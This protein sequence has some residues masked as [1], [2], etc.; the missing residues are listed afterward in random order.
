M[1]SCKLSLKNMIFYGH[2]GVYSFE[3]E[4]GQRIEVD[5]ELWADFSVAVK[6]DNL[7]AAIS[8]VDVYKTVKNIVEDESYN[9]IEGMAV[10]IS[11]RIRADYDVSKVT[12]RVRKPQPP[13]GGLMDSA[14]FEICLKKE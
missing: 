5:V 14:E 3:K 13:V 11:E 9:L 2:H 8:Y 6:T 7:D 12:V 10:A 1:D 4:F